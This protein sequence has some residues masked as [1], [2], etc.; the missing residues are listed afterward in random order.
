MASIPAHA[1]FLVIRSNPT[2]ARVLACSSG[3]VPKYRNASPAR[4]YSTACWT[5]KTS[6]SK[7]SRWATGKPFQLFR[8]DVNEMNHLLIGYLKSYPAQKVWPI[9]MTTFPFLCPASTY[10]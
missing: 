10:L 1:D 5:G 2:R 9:V 8:Q 4:L 7:L 6:T 3:M